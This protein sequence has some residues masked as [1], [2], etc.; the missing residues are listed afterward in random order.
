MSFLK[1]LSA[2]PQIIAV[3][4]C[5]PLV[6]VPQGLQRLIDKTS[7][8]SEPITIQKLRTSAKEIELGKRFSGESDW[9]K[10]LTVT[11]QNVSSKAIA[12]IELNL[13][14]P[15][16]A[17]TS[18][19]VTTYVVRMIY[20][21]E[22]SDPSYTQTQKPV[23]PGESA[24]VVLPDVNIPLIKIDLDSL[25]Y[26]QGSSHAQIRVDSVTFLDGTTWAGDEML[27]PDPKSPTH[28]LNP[29]LQRPTSVPD[30]SKPYKS[31]SLSES[32]GARF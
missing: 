14:F 30:L 7:W 23:L 15:R 9:L 26:P 17:G 20:G 29:R 11:V 32:W 10:G 31:T 21:L 18:S 4:T 1:L 28:K 19:Q 16:P 8:R 13:A 3:I 27:F 24:D 2:L 25:G 22:P 6:V 12:R 5:L